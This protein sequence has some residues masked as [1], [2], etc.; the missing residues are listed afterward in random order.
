M[1]KWK[2]I[3]WGVVLIAL[4]V[5][6]ALNALNVTDIDIF[7][8]GWWTLFIIVPGL[9]ALFTERDKMGGLIGV[10]IGV[11][12]LLASRDVISFDMI[13]KLILP[14][15]IVLIGLR[16]IIGGVRRRPKVTVER[17]LGTGAPTGGGYCS[18]FSGQE[19]RL[20]GQVF[21]GTTVTAVFGGV[22]LDL[23]GAIIEQ[24]CE[25]EVVSVFGGVDIWLPDTVNVKTSSVSIFGGMDNK[26]ANAL[27]DT[28]VTV[29]ITGCCIFGGADVQ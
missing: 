13:W 23:R 20:D 9:T 6:L 3:L 27:S 21:T 8:D 28:A 10:C 19:V 2:K 11:V 16:L 17:P 18:V 4:G 12:F 25:I 14:A 7:F 1:K 5:V 26:K 15:V 29:H 24:D 22:D